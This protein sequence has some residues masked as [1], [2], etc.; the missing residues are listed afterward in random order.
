MA[1]NTSAVLV[2]RRDDAGMVRFLRR[3]M[4]FDNIIRIQQAV[5]QGDQLQDY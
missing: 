3:N 4:N 5:M 2:A 1:E